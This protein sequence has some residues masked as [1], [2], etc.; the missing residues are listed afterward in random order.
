M[1]VNEY[2][3]PFLN[4]PDPKN[5]K[6]FLT[7]GVKRNLANRMGCELETNIE[8]PSDTDTVLSDDAIGAFT[9]DKEH[10]HLYLAVNS[11]MVRYSIPYKLKEDEESS[12][13]TI[14]L[15]T[16]YVIYNDCIFK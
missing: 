3:Y 9:K 12:F 11:N 13:D 6:L 1:F 2:S 14:I 7:N 8:N 15:D 10:I 5:T 16:N 4:L